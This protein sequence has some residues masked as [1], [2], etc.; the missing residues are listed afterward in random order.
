MMLTREEKRKCRKGDTYSESVVKCCLKSAFVG[1][2]HLLLPDILGLINVTSKIVSQCSLVFNR[3]LIH[4]FETSCEFPNLNDEKLYIQCGTIGN[5]RLHKPIPLVYEV[6]NTHFVPLKFPIINRLEGDRVSIQYACQKYKTNFITMVW[7]PFEKRLKKFVRI[8]CQRNGIA[9]NTAFTICRRIIGLDETHAY[10]EELVG[11]EQP[12]IAIQ[13]TNLQ[14]EF[15]EHQRALLGLNDDEIV[16]KSWL[17]KN[18]SNVLRFY[19][20]VI[21]LYKAWEVKSFSLAP[22]SSVRQIFT[23]IDTTVF[24]HMLKRQGWVHDS[25]DLKGFSSVA[26]CYWNSFFKI[27]E[28]QN[29]YRHKFTGLIETDGVSL[30]IHYLKPIAKLPPP[31]P[32]PRKTNAK[33]QRGADGYIKCRLSKNLPQPVKKGPVIGLDPGRVNIAQTI[34]KLEDGTTISRRLTRKTYYQESSFN[35]GNRKTKKWNLEIKDILIEMS[36]VTPKTVDPK[37]WKRYLLLYIKHY[38]VLWEHYSQKKWGRQRFHLYTMKRKCIDKFFASLHRKGEQKPI[39]AYGAAAFG[40]TGRREVSVPTIAFA[41]ASE[42]HYE[43]R[44]VNEDYSTKMCSFCGNE[45]HKVMVKVEGESREVRG[46]R[47]CSTKCRKLLN[48]DENA[49]LNILR[50]FV[51]ETRPPE[52]TRVFHQRKPRVPLGSHLIKDGLLMDSPA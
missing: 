38:K 16:S 3:L 25:I 1:V 48:R 49:A 35:E 31:L 7:Y 36:T 21:Q 8:W 12:E 51:S 40:P 27:E 10:N 42:R 44:Y 2:G 11:Q 9:K 45:T 19:Y 32:P 6:W 14:E 29:N 41:K 39:I 52:L 5:A 33:Y 24:Y 17:K 30:C 18:I 23:T 47:W 37:D 28:R 46:L 26:T 13:T 43:T 20:E 50:C 22:I 34:E 15:I 4:C